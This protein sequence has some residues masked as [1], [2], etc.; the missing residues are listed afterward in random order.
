MDNF[1]TPMLGELAKQICA[2]EDVVS[3]RFINKKGEVV[4]QQEAKGRTTAVPLQCAM[5]MMLQGKEIGTAEVSYQLKRL[6]VR[7]TEIATRVSDLRKQT[8]IRSATL[9]KEALRSSLVSG[10]I[11]VTAAIVIALLCLVPMI[12][13][14]L[15][16]LQAGVRLAEAVGRGDVSGHLE[17]RSRDEIGRLGLALNSMTDNLRAKA[18][19][20]EA[21]ADGDLSHRVEIASQEDVLGR[22]LQRM[23]EN[24]NTLLGSVHTVATQ[25]NS[26]A[27]QM[28]ASS[29]ALSQGAVESAA[30][31]EQITASMTQIGSQ[32]K[33]NA[34][35]AAQANQMSAQ[36]KDAAE[37]GAVRMDKLVSAMGGIQESSQMIAKILKTIDDIAFQ[38]N[39]L[40]LNAAIEAARAGR[41]GKGF[42]VVADEVR[43][44]AGRCTKAAK[45]TSTLIDESTRRVGLGTETA[46]EAATAFDAIVQRITKV[47][48]LVGEI[49]IASNEQAEGA[50]QVSQGLEQIDQVTQQ[51]TASAEETSAATQELE[52]QAA[53]LRKLLGQ[54]Q[55]RDAGE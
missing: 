21:I 3:F 44:L 12:R 41:H 22:A 25:V 2:D 4:A 26:G 7:R 27:E 6:D 11:A 9:T 20:A 5:K 29:Q 1:D 17:V 31:I 47:N 8:E 38:T 16:P 14:L 19:V 50:S 55:L 37:A 48:D 39:L 51:N 10:A 33:S 34:E 43:S 40:A 24:L 54:F 46:Q 45:E 28:S 52:G 18:R 32:A 23:S 42:A 53:E 15:R 36:T 35:N 49:A 30:S 13:V